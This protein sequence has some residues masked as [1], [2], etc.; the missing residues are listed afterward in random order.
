MR[1][2]LVR[3]ALLIA[4]GFALAGCAREDGNRIIGK[5]RAERMEVMS[6]KLPLGPHIEITRE[7]L[8]A[9]PGIAIPIVG[10]TQDGDEVTLETDALIGMTFRFVDAD[11]IY[12]ELPVVGRLY[13]LREPDQ[14]TGAASAAAPVPVAASNPVVASPAPAA[15]APVARVAVEASV[16]QAQAV[17]AV[18]DQDVAH[19][20]VLL[21]QGDHDN[22][23]RSL[24]T[25]FSQGFRDTALLARTP[26][27]DV[28]KGDVRYQALLARY[29]Q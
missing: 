8:T 11:R 3:P 25:A 27:F 4:L 6:L 2:A 24:H 19:A 22:A 7:A 15:P 28:L 17:E 29:G 9:G 13:Y 14:S 5:W 20:L 10:I 1:I 26:A 23:V 21:G 18:Q 16:P 12:F